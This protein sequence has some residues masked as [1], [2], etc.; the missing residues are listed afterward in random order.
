MTAPTAIRT[1]ATTALSP[2]SGQSR[3]RVTATVTATESPDRLHA[4]SVRSRARPGSLGPPSYSG[5]LVCKAS[6]DFISNR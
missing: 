1:N 3:R 6:V 4:S 5:S 2:V